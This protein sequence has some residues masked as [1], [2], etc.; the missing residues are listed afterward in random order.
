VKLGPSVTQSRPTNLETAQSLLA[1]RRMTPFYRFLGVASWP[2]LHGLYRLEVRGL[3]RLPSEGGYVLASNHASNFDPW[4]LGMPL[5]PERQLRFMAKSELF[6]PVLAPFVWAGGG[7]PVK[8]GERDLEA[9]ETAVSLVRAGE[10]VVMFP[11]G[12][13][14]KKGLNK[15]FEAR[16]RTGTARIALEAG[17]PLVPA[18]IEGTGRLS[19]LERLRVAFGAPVP[20][21]D[22]RGEKPDAALVATE[23]LMDAIAEL[24]R[25]L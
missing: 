23:R 5:Y 10:I 20:L 8:R 24:R 15:K 21:D 1:R 6:N 9:I 2:F 13:R 17:V 4:L 12:T 18:A 3:E 16:P 11:E 22:L 14:Q 19:R 25:D 7:F